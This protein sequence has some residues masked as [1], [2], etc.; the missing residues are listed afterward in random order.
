V[1][2]VGLAAEGALVSI[3]AV[4]LN[5][6]PIAATNS[7]TVAPGNTIGVD[8]LV[9]DWVNELL[10]KTYQIK[11]LGVFGFG[12][13]SNG[14]ILPVGWKAP[15]TKIPCTTPAECPSN[16]PLCDPAVYGC[17]ASGHFPEFHPTNNPQGPRIN[18][19]RADFIFAPPAG[20]SALGVDS[21]SL[22]YRFT[23]VAGK[24]APSGVADPGVPRYAGHFFLQV[25]SSACGQFTIGTDPETFLAAA[26]NEPRPVT[27]QALVL[28]VTNCNT[29][30]FSC[31]PGHCNQDS[32]RPHSRTAAPPPLDTANSIVMTFDRS[33]AG[34][35]T[36]DFEAETI[37]NTCALRTVQQVTVNSPT[38]NDITVRLN[39]R[40]EPECWTCI[41]HKGKDKRCCVG[42]LP[43]DSNWSRVSN[44]SDILDPVTPSAVNLTNN[45]RGMVSP[46]LRMEQCDMDRSL[47]CTGA[48][49]LEAVDL[50]N[51]A[52]FYDAYNS[53][54]LPECPS[55]TR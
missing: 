6:N 2:G 54:F 14:T 12:S 53:A 29:Q 41:R 49:V 26:D 9:S 11:L 24:D 7:L 36:T 10:V 30:L 37:P 34:M 50:L 42:I 35:A 48:D 33:T 40:F 27:S 19:T 16:Y 23:S 28:T 21:S 55:A 45:L 8:I 39:L 22:N 4:S 18:T 5:G 43:A 52:E 46:A 32:R 15:L 1:L 51:G 47:L 25:G 31:T 13:G 20:T 44:I 38:T 17:H 3:K